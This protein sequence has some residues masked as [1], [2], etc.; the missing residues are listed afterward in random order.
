MCRWSFVSVEK[1][2]RPFTVGDPYFK[3]KSSR[4]KV[5]GSKVMMSRSRKGKRKRK[6]KQGISHAG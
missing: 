6:E 1:S 4:V 5:E 3:V 2:H